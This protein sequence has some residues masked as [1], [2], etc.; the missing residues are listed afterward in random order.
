VFAGWQ[1]EAERIPSIV[2]LDAGFDHF[3]NLE[4][5]QALAIF[6]ADVAATHTADAYNHVAQVLVFRAMFRAGALDTG[7]VASTKA[8]LQTKVPMNEDDRHQFL[9]SL[10]RAQKAAEEAI[11]RNPNDTNA[12]YSLGVSHGLMADYDMF[13]AKSYLDALRQMNTARMDHNR[14]TAIDPKMLD[15]QLLQGVYDYVVASLPWGWRMLGFLGG[16][17][18]DRER[19]IQTLERVAKDGHWNKVDA[20]IML[21]AIYRRENKPQQAIA[22]VKDLCPR[23]PR[24]YLVRLQLADLY[25]YFG[26]RE[27][28]RRVMAE[29]GQK[30]EQH[31]PGFERVPMESLRTL[32]QRID[33]EAMNAHK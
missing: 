3:Y 28:A 7:M 14:A 23:M 4:Y 16:Y 12:W 2:F 26:D 15:A 1:A 22:E 25:C 10:D 31:A 5:D 8:F 33:S 9:D 11:R 30:K 24:N 27:Q 20:Q 6:E 17:R 13:V 32:E 19:G 29:I 18:G 21:A